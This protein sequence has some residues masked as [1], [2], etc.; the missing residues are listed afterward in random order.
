VLGKVVGSERRLAFCCRRLRLKRSA[1]TRVITAT[2]P[3]TP[4]TIEPVLVFLPRTGVEAGDVLAA[5]EFV[6]EGEEVEEPG[7]FP[8]DIKKLTK[9]T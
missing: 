8:V 1:E 9:I 2:P 3:S 5:G 4:P 6:L 7:E